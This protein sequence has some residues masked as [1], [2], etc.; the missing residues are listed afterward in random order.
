MK[1][2]RILW[3]TEHFSPVVGGTSESCFRQVRE[4][5][6]SGFEIDIVA[7]I[8]S[9]RRCAMDIVE[10]DCGRDIF[11]TDSQHPMEGVLKIWNYL[12]LE[13]ERKPYSRVV[14]FGCGRAGF[15]ASTFSK[16]MERPFYLLVQGNDFDRFWFDNGNGWQIKEAISCASNIGCVS[17]ELIKRI[18]LLFPQKNIVQTPRGVDSSRWMLSG[19]DELITKEIKSDKCF[20]NRTIIG[21]FGKMQYKKQ[22]WEWLGSIRKHGLNEKIGLLVVGWIDEE[23]SR[24][25]DDTSSPNNRRIKFCTLDNM[26]ALYAACD[27][28]IIPSLFEGMPNVLLESMAMGIP[29]IASDAGAMSEVIIHGENGFIFPAGNMS[30]AADTTKTAL[31]LSPDERKNMGAKAKEH[32]FKNFSVTKEFETIKSL[33]FNTPEQ[34]IENK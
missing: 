19:T 18:S 1:N 22:T 11:V 29:V 28:T 16:W 2:N 7:L 12:K 15:V 4:F 6:K 33:I 27:F 30:A 20:E 9:K 31:N 34:Q 25:L 8:Y 3:L 21:I 26:P 24:I 32:V 5:R 17:K 14:G 13:H 23:T 10:R